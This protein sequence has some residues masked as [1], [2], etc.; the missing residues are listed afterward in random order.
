[1]PEQCP[2]C[3]NNIYLVQSSPTVI[4]L[5]KGCGTFFNAAL[6]A[7]GDLKMG[8]DMS[9]VDSSSAAAK[10]QILEQE[11]VKEIQEEQ[12]TEQPVKRTENMASFLSGSGFSSEFG[13]PKCGSGMKSMASPVTGNILYTCAKCGYTGTVYV[14]K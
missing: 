11:P 8:L 2:N 5:C 3:Q 1:M 10:P 9:R 4:L 14:K 12:K 7:V 6:Q 13:C